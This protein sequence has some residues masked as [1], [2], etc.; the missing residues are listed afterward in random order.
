MMV[1]W[2]HETHPDTSFDPRTTQR[3]RSPVSHHQGSPAADPRADG[4]PRGGTRA[5]GPT[6]GPHCPRA[7]GDRAP[8]AQ[9]LSGRGDGRLT[10]CPPPWTPFADDR[11]GHG[12]TVG[13]WAPPTAEL[14]APVLI[15][16]APALGRLLGRAH[17]PSG[18]G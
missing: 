7:R 8:L 18:L 10:R 2:R 15:V 17:R 9:T 13:G 3:T 16:D 1:Y 4:L 6:D 12:R 11:G 14:R 5:Q